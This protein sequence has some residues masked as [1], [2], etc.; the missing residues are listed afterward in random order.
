MSYTITTA[1]SH[2]ASKLKGF[3]LDTVPG[4]DNYFVFN[5]AAHRLIADAHLH[6][7]VR[8]SVLPS[9]VHESITAYTIPSDAGKSRIIDLYENTNGRADSFTNVNWSTFNRNK[10]NYSM[11]VTRVNGTD[12]LN[13]KY[14]KSKQATAIGISSYNTD[15]EWISSSNIS[16]ITRDTLLPYYAGSC[17][18]F[19]IDAAS[20]SEIQNTTIGTKDLS[21]YEDE[22]FFFVPVYMPSASSFTSVTFKIGSSSS[23]YWT[24]TAT[25]DFNGN[26]FVDG[27]NLVAF[28]WA[29]MTETGTPVVT[30]ID[31]AAVGFVTTG[32]QIQNVRLD[33]IIVSIGKY[34]K[35]RYYS[36]YFFQ[37]SSGAWIEN[38]TSNNDVLMVDNTVYQLYLDYCVVEAYENSHDFN[39]RPQD[40]ETQV[41]LNRAKEN[42]KNYEAR[43]KSEI[44]KQVTYYY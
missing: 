44:R 7:L 18:K 22:G 30:G 33:N 3:N 2:L 8:E 16:D 25:T 39:Y 34:F 4:V 14:P 29:S 15:G 36:N 31:Y 9:Q 19:T 28:D 11:N 17:M 35:L 21:D 41:A 40:S 6:T 5:R 10:A 37:N 43:Y 27:W 26:A 13:M 12:F 38:A 1:K 24:A 20:P 32:S 23:D 42:L